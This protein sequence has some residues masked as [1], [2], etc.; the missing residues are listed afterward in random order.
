MPHAGRALVRALF[1]LT[2]T[3]LIAGCEREPGPEPAP[4]SALP[5]PDGVRLTKADFDALPGWRADDPTAALPALERSCDKLDSLPADRPVGPDGYAGTAGDWTKACEALNRLP[6]NAKPAR[7][8]EVL[9]AR[10]TPFA[11]HGP[12]GR[13]GLFTGYYESTL[14][15]ARTRRGPYRYPLYAPPENLIKV[16]LGRF[17]DELDGKRIVGRVK[18]GRLVPFHGRKAID[19]GVLDGSAR[20]LLWADDPVDVFFLHIQGSGVATLPD[21]TT[22]RIGYAASNG[23]DFTAIGRELIASGARDGQDMSMQAIRDWLRAHPGKAEDLMHRNA[24]Y[25]FF[26]E[27]EGAGPIGAYGVPLT[28]RRSLA[29]DPEKMPLGA[30]IWLATTYPADDAPLRRLMVAQDTGSAIKGAVRGDFFWGHG[31]AA[32]AEAGRMKQRGRYWVLLPK[33]VVD[34][35][36]AAS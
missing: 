4:E 36:A 33:A 31:D 10:F 25:I 16:N 8:R 24:R 17:S 30:P 22:Q 27:I 23:R 3:L 7:V 13:E 2:V 18:D 11:V 29:V 32:L 5:T 28:P 14:N 9:K 20:V 6:A 19:A 26:R 15:A 1:G 12:E 21:G 35:V 34:R